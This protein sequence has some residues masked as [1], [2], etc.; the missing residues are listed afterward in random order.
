MGPDY[1]AR[2]LRVAGDLDVEWVDLPRRFAEADP[3]FRGSALLHD[4]VHPDERGNAVI[5]EAI[6]GQLLVSR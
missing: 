6:A 2:L 3:A 4:W 1:D 5:A